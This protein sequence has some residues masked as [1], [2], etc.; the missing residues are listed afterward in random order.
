MGE[1]VMQL[2]E[3]SVVALITGLLLL[4]VFSGVMLIKAVEQLN[5]RNAIVR[6]KVMQ[7]QALFIGE[8][9]KPL[10]TLTKQQCRKASNAGGFKKVS[11]SSGD[12]RG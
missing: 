3:H 12:F 5:N 1:C 4:N 9:R 2:V 11:C 10:I 7:D 6:E 8:L